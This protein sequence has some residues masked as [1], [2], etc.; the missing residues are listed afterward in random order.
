MVLYWT[1]KSASLFSKLT[2]L[3][4]SSTGHIRCGWSGRPSGRGRVRPGGDWSGN[5][6]RLLSGP[7]PVTARPVSPL[8]QC[9]NGHQQVARG[10]TSHYTGLSLQ[11]TS[12]QCANVVIERIFVKRCQPNIDCQRYFNMYQIIDVSAKIII[13]LQFVTDKLVSLK[14]LWEL[15][16]LKLNIKIV[17][18][19]SHRGCWG[20]SN[21]SSN[22]QFYSKK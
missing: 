15:V 19:V 9:S 2:S 10:A 20:L 18:P 4:L 12:F 21:A 1:I 5:Q 6:A 17:F 11:Q 8:L 3:Q 14:Y 16:S 7:R 22:F 13:F